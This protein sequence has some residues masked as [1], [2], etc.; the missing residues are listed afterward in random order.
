VIKDLRDLCGAAPACEFRPSGLKALRERWVADRMTRGGVNR[1]AGIVR[2]VFRWAVA[3]EVVPPDVS[4]RLGA[5][6][7]LRRGRTTAPDRPPVQPIDETSYLRTRQAALPM[8]AALMTVQRLTGMR[9][10]EVC[11]LRPCDLDTSG[12]VWR[13]VPSSHKT[14]HHGRARVVYL[15]PKAQMVLRPWLPDGPTAFCFPGRTGRGHILPQSYAEGVRRAAERAGLGPWSPNRL[16]HLYATELRQRFDAETAR[17]VLGHA[18]LSTTEIYAERDLS[19]A[20]RVAGEV[21]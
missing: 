2:R 1:L 8:I 13:Y 9:P 21:G 11:R 17:V 12:P 6:T 20:A 15:G 5:V 4:A 19:A 16:R 3:E 14:E 18:K 10:G 7:D